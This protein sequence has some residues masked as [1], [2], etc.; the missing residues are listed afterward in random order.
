MIDDLRSL[1]I[2]ATVAEMGSFT[3]AARRL[4]LTTS[5][6]SH[7]VSKLEQRLD[8]ALL[9]RSTRSLSLTSEGR[10]LLPAA[11]DMVRAAEQGLEQI[12]EGG[13]HAAGELTLTMP[14][15]M[16]SSLYEAAIW[17]FARAHP[18][19]AIN[20]H[21]SDRQVDLI[22]EGY[23][24]A[25]RLGELQDST[26]QMRKLGSFKRKLVCAPSYLLAHGP[27]DTIE[28]LRKCHFVEMDM[29]PD[30]LILEQ[31]GERM[32]IHTSASRIRVNSIIAAHSVVLCGLAVQ[33]LPLTQIE[34]DLKSGALV[35]LLPEWS[36]PQLGVYAVWPETGSGN[37]VRKLIE[38][39]ATD[40]T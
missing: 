26:L 31:A 40:Y 33:R 22:R 30:G 3:A 32:E 9:Y 5:V 24:L 29:V 25:I 23:D 8:V 16:M 21:N 10:K 19:V 13:D 4:R 17:S 18:H 2:F 7:H 28:A 6:V 20:L 36:L 12:D 11:Q 1:A 14:A 39:L 34:D 38:H 15:F 37:L 27:V 35:E